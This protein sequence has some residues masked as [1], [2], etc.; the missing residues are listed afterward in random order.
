MLMQ[1]AAIEVLHPSLMFSKS[2]YGSLYTG[3]TK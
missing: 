3:G 1:Y 2:G